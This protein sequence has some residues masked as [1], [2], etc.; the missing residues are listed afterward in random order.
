MGFG[1]LSNKPPTVEV[2][3][4]PGGARLLLHPGELGH[5]NGGR[6]LPGER[7]QLFTVLESKAVMTEEHKTKTIFSNFS[8]FRLKRK[9]IFSSPVL[10]AAR[11][12]SDVCG[13]AR[14]PSVRS[15]VTRW[16]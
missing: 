13:L 5:R 7:Q 10:L 2:N 11:K 3:E 15:E 4:Q 14:G 16:L 8:S 12:K 6:I 9:N 1:S